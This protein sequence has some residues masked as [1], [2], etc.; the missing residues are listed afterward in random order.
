MAKVGIDAI[1]NVFDGNDE[2]MMDMTPEPE[3]IMSHRHNA[4]RDINGLITIPASSL[5][6][7]YVCGGVLLVPADDE[8]DASGVTKNATLL[9]KMKS[10]NAD[11]RP[12]TRSTS[13][14]NH[15][16]T[17]HSNA[18][19]QRRKSSFLT[20]IKPPVEKMG[21]SSHGSS[22]SLCSIVDYFVGRSA[23]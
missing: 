14:S 2:Q 16:T 8:Y 3:S 17:N 11:N 6:I 20:I 22:A 7:D 4:L 9:M 5:G 13:G 10:T 18:K 21:S 15:S 12:Y 1:D 19:Y 23:H